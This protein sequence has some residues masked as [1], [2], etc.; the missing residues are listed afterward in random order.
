MQG[1]GVEFGK[2]RLFQLSLVR[3]RQGDAEILHYRKTFANNC[4]IFK[5]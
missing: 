3:V 5:V 4:S 2:R 1:A